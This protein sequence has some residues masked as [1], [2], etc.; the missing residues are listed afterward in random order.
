M[1]NNTLM[2]VYSA[3][4]TPTTFKYKNLPFAAPEH[5]LIDMTASCPRC[6][7][8]AASKPNGSEGEW[9]NALF[10]SMNDLF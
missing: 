3:P 7:A 6:L 9:V 2:Y 5:S 8:N 10:F 4:P 1:I